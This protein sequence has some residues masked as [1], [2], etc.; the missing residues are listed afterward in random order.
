MRATANEI[1]DFVKE[2]DVKFIRLTFC[3]LFGCQKN[4][5]I[6]PDEL[7]LAFEEGVPFY[8]NAVKGF[9]ES[10]QSELLLFPD[11]ST[12]S[13]L[14][15]RPQQG[16]VIRLLCYI[17]NPDGKPFWGDSR[18]ILKDT[19]IRLYEKGLDCSIS[20][21]CEFYLFKTN[22]KEEPTSIPFDNAG[23]LD[24]APLDKCENIRREIC[25]CLEEMGIKPENSHHGK[26]PGQNV[27]K[28]K[29][30]DIL[31]CADNIVTFKTAVKT[32]AARNGLYASF[33]PKPL[34][35]SNGNGINLN[36]TLS[37][38]RENVIL[39][40]KDE[41]LHQAESFIAGVLQRIPEITAFLNPLPNSYTR[42]QLFEEPDTITRIIMPK[43]PDT[44]DELKLTIVSPDLA[45]NPYIA[46]SLI[47]AAG[48]DGM[49]SEITLIERIDNDLGNIKQKPNSRPENLEKALKLALQSD[50]VKKVLPEP[51]LL[52]YNNIKHKEF[53]DFSKDIGK[54]GFYE[55]N[56]LNMI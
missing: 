20:P 29:S 34:P 23:Y 28:L 46:L 16:R 36:L 51:L 3:D 49:E 45:A 43:Y 13:V 55:D 12:L 7:T 14:P 24:V 15:W 1:L 56:C 35:D 44:K 8:S 37:Q 30:A 22:E 31:K 32:I 53:Q 47:I 25:L 39:L 9:E 48:I 6:M 33:A 5:S 27:I 2:N 54:R 26:G 17:N 52:S 40:S 38:D 18:K 21:E 42:Q 11:P 10:E 4:I 41:F 19:L 50:F